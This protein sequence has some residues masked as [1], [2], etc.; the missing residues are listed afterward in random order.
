MRALRF[1]LAALALATGAVAAEGRCG[2]DPARYLCTGDSDYR[3]FSPRLL[4]LL[5]TGAA[6]VEL[7]A[8]FDAVPLGEGGTCQRVILWSREPVVR[9]P[10]IELQARRLGVVCLGP[11]VPGPSRH[12]LTWHLGRL[13]PRVYAVALRD[14]TSQR[15]SA[16]F[17]FEVQPV[18]PALSLR[19]GFVAQVVYG[20]DDLS[21]AAVKLTSE[22]SYFA[23]QAPDNVELTLKI[24][25]GRALN[26]HHWVFLASMTDQPFTLTVFD[27]RGGC[28]SLPGDPRQTCAHRDYVGVA[29]QNR[30]VLDTAAFSDPAP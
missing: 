13:E 5:P 2:E 18:T 22:S 16:A 4:P 3:S 7:H 8:S 26:G 11:G 10:K 9:G 28:L 14:V 21:A 30:N 23:F 12:E 25:D 29:G 6:D 27:N 24:L 1:A 17:S 15:K 20:G 19:D